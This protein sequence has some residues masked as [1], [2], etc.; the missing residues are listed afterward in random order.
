MTNFD[1]TIVS[2]T[3]D[4]SFMATLLAKQRFVDCQLSH[5]FVQAPKMAALKGLPRVF[6]IIVASA[7]S[8]LAGWFLLTQTSS[9]TATSQVVAPKKSSARNSSAGTEPI[10]TPDNFD[11][12]A[13]K[14][15]SPDL[16]NLTESE[17]RQHYLREGRRQGR[18]CRRPPLF[19]TYDAYGGL[20][21]Q[22]LAHIEG[23]A[24]AYNLNATALTAYAYSRS[25]FHTRG[26]DPIWSPQPLESL[27]DF[28][29]WAAYWRGVGVR[30]AKVIVA[31]FA[32]ACMHGHLQRPV[33]RQVLCCMLCTATLCSTANAAPAIPTLHHIPCL[34]VWVVQSTNTS[35]CAFVDLTTRQK[36]PDERHPYRLTSDLSR[37]PDPMFTLPEALAQLAGHISRAARPRLKANPTAAHCVHLDLENPATIFNLPRSVCMMGRACTVHTAAI[38]VPTSTSGRLSYL[39]LLRPCRSQPYM[40]PI[41]LDAWPFA[42]KVVRAADSILAILAA[43]KHMPFLGVHLR[44]ESDFLDRLQSSTTAAVR[45]HCACRFQSD[46]H[47]S[48]C[49][50][51]G[52]CCACAAHVPSF[53]W[54]ATTYAAL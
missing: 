23:L 38:A 50:L 17:A 13:Y 36:L 27:L 41:T 43:R 21:N 15:Y 22:L 54:C 31:A 28:E 3:R 49:S 7:A 35:G 37:W 6:L 32:G 24:L 12:E 26:A 34:P 1:E 52:H 9:Q 33:F 11:W 8:L 4:P 45:Q 14:F 51:Y 53:I 18:I 46:V 40:P 20:C 2:V 30:V 47:S 19:L 48:L 16:A 39:P 42:P 5:V 10:A 29:A 25:S 44:I